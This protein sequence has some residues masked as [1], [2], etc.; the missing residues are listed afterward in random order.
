MTYDLEVIPDGRKIE[1]FVAGTGGIIL[2][3]TFRPERVKQM[4][5]AKGLDPQKVLENIYVARC[6]N[7]DHQMLLAEKAEEIVKEKNVKVIIV[8][9]VTGH[10]RGD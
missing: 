4:A 7:S 10:F 8:D 1:N 9:S 5:A 6:Y 3:N 2:H